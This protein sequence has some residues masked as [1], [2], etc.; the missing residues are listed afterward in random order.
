MLAK[1]NSL[2]FEGIEG[3]HVVVEVNIANGIPAFDVVGLPGA[4]VRESRERVKAAITNSN[5]I[6]PIKRITANLAPADK[7]KEG[8]IYDLPIA[9]GVLCANGAINADISKSCF[10]GEL[11][12]DGSVRGIRGV[13]AML[14]EAINQGFDKIYIPSSNKNE[15]ACI[16]GIEIIPIDNLVQ[17]IKILNAKEKTVT[18]KVV[19]YRTLVENSKSHIDFSHIKGQFMA[20]RALEIAAAGGHNLLMIGPPGSGKTMLA[21]A[22]S[23]IMPP[24]SFDEAL[25]VTKIHSIAGI[26]DSEEG[27]VLKR[28]FRSPHHTSSSIALT[29]GG[30]KVRPGEISL[31]HNGVLFLDEFPEFQRQVL[32]AL[33]QP[34][35]DGVITVSRASGTAVFPSNIML[36]ASMN[37]CPCGHY[38]A[39]TGQCTCN[40]SQ[41]SRYLHKISG[42]LLDRLDIHVEV[43]SVPFSQLSRMDGGEK[44]EDIAKRVAKARAVQQGRYK[45]EGIYRNSQLQP[46]H[47]NKYCKLDDEGLNILKQYFSR[48]SLSARA[49]DRVIKIARTIADLDD[50]TNIEEKHLLEALQY[51]T[52]DRKYWVNG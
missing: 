5:Q 38:G 46:V 14:V 34:L 49:Y 30:S 3:Y 42:P 10:I 7:K 18:L 37:P 44:S 1:I 36:V 24:L 31:A 41:I 29:G 40:R 45:D 50:S 15:V 20:K 2:G 35:E 26:L 16:N 8:A 4:T 9:L 33:R 25:E 19:D 32:E 23:G 48:L 43:D 13:I 47:K 17:L 12:L 52:L 28:P 22:L 6:F 51:R 21:T 27:I 11:S 39:S